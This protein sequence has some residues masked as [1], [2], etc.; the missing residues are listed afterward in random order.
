L[1]PGHDG[2]PYGSL[3][4][5]GCA[6]DGA[7]ILL[8]S[9]LAE[10]AKAIA[11]DHRV[12]LLF[13]NVGGLD[14]PLTGARVTVM[15]TARR[16]TDPDDRARYLARHPSAAGYADFADFNFYRLAVT[17]AHL[18]AGFGKIHWIES[19]ALLFDTQG[20]EALG[21]AETDIVTHM[22]QDHGDAIDLYAQNLLG[23]DGEGWS[24]TGVD[25]E[26]AD[27]RLGGRVARVGFD[28]PVADADGAR[29]ELVRLVKRA[30]DGR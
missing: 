1:H 19:G 28:T 15:G 23:L 20:S 30:R 8:I 3:V 18:V 10:H 24:L 16:S 9:D 17:R 11:A 26:G 29:A 13:D 7:P 4:L 5:T 2:W 14:D 27:L 25:P 6:H 22:N 21:A 12:S